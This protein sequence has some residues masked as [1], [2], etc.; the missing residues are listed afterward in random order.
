M[1]FLFIL[2]TILATSHKFG[3]RMFPLLVTDTIL[4]FLDFLNLIFLLFAIFLFSFPSSHG[5]EFLY[6][7]SSLSGFSKNVSCIFYKNIHQDELLSAESCHQFH[8]P[9]SGN[10]ILP[11]LRGC[12][13]LTYRIF[14]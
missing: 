2:I 6:P 14:L 9:V 3:F 5:L 1:S 13:T 8:V 11:K 4:N 10:R 7:I 12:G